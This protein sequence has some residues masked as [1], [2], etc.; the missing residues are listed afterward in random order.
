MWRFTKQFDGGTRPKM[1][2]YA[3]YQVLLCTLYVV[4]RTAF[5]TKAVLTVPFLRTSLWTA[6][7]WP[8]GGISCGTMRFASWNCMTIPQRWKEHPWR[9]RQSRVQADTRSDSRLEPKFLQVPVS[10]NSVR[11][12]VVA[13]YMHSSRMKILT[14]VCACACVCA[15]VC[16]CVCIYIQGLQKIRVSAAWDGLLASW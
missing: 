4:S 1:E 14:A 6:C 13:I 8:Q 7:A 2:A 15:C 10:V 3:S 16:V 11:S 9:R 12:I 5:T